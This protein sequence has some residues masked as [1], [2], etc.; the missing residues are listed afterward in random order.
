MKKSKKIFCF[1][2][3]SCIFALARL[4]LCLRKQ[5]QQF[6]GT[7]SNDKP[8]LSYSFL[9]AF[10]NIYDGLATLRGGVFFITLLFKF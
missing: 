6:K 9:F 3:N 5:I 4:S 1:S 7:Y 8:P 2:E 10:V